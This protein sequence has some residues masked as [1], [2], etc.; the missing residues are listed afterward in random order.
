MT[1]VLYV[2]PGTFKASTQ[3][4]DGLGDED[5]ERA[6]AAASAAVEEMCHRRF[7]LDPED[8]TRTY[9][10]LSSRMVV[11]DDVAT[12]TSVTSAG[13]AIASYVAEPLNATVD[14]KP[15]K[16]LMSETVALSCERGAIAVTGR[17]GWPQVPVQVEQ[18]VTIVAAKLL[19][20]TR[21]APFGVI[22]SGGLD[23]PAA[24]RLAREDPD[25]M[26]LIRPLTRSHPVVA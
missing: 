12:I 23:S 5:V 11:V 16:W 7:W 26:L 24:I 1:T 22:S 8:T 3:I 18:F 9:T 14:G 2:P 21:E 25:A 13:T 20:R 6:L 15:F 17:F 10:A 4:P 19:K